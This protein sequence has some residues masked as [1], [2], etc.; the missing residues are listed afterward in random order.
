MV[1][2]RPQAITQPWQAEVPVRMVWAIS[3]PLT[4]SAPS[5]VAWVQYFWGISPKT[6]K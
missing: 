5:K 4:L 3:A 6:C 2:S 1:T